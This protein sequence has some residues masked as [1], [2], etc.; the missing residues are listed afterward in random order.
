[1]S[2]NCPSLSED[3]RTTL[4]AEM[5]KDEGTEKVPEVG[6]GNSM[7]CSYVEGLYTYKDPHTLKEYTWDEDK[8]LWTPK[9]VE[10]F[11]DGTHHL[12]EDKDGQIMFWD[13]EKMNWLPKV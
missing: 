5:E 4:I 12:Y 7:Y 3:L 9:S 1:M 13:I 2:S 11:F 6:L 8:K 10:V